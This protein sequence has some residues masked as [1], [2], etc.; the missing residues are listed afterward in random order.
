MVMI[1]PGELLDCLELRHPAVAVE[2]DDE[3]HL[4]G[5]G[6][7]AHLLV[8]APLL[9]L[10]PCVTGV[11]CRFRLWFPPFSAAKIM[12][13]LHTAKNGLKNVKFLYTHPACFQNAVPAEH[14]TCRQN[15]H[16]GCR[17]ENAPCG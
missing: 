10:L 5:S 1:H 6:N 16:N 9:A 12:H 17:Q 13:N 14:S 7:L 3:E 8:P 4:L 15:E 11:S 2:G